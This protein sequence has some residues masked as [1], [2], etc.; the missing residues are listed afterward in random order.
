MAERGKIA[1][2]VKF[3]NDT[4]GYGFITRDDGEDDVFVHLQQLR[5]SPAHSIEENDQV[6]FDVEPGKEGKGFRARNIS[7]A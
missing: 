7:L 4:K 6:F 1:G 5:A 3:F 2:K